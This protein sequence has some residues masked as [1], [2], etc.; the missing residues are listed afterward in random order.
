MADR[1]FVSVALAFLAGVATLASSQAAFAQAGVRYDR[2]LEIVSTEYVPPE[3][4]GGKQLI[5]F[6]FNIAEGV[7]AGAKIHMKIQYTG[8][9]VDEKVLEV[10]AKRKDVVYE[11]RPDKKLGPDDAFQLFRII[12]IEEQTP[13]VVE[14]LKKSKDLPWAARPWPYSPPEEE[15]FTIGT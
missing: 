11:W 8:L 14:A 12:P 15:V 10:G 6:K 13:A 9:A 5:R 3:K 7:P 2:Y 4:A 1:G